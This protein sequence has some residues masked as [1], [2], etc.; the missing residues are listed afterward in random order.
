MCDWP[1][2]LADAM[3]SDA[4]LKPNH[5]QCVHFWTMAGNITMALLCDNHLQRADYCMGGGT[6][7]VPLNG[8]RVLKLVLLFL[9][10]KAPV[11]G[12]F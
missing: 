2:N 12:T 8:L 9:G 11:V 1:S 10:A 7:W 5:T 4:S 6:C 3:S